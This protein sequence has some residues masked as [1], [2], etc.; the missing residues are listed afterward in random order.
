[1]CRSGLLL[2]IL[3]GC[4]IAEPDDLGPDAATGA[5]ETTPSGDPT[6]AKITLSH[7][8]STA[9][10]KSASVAC[11]NRDGST[12]E[13][14]WY[15][16]FRLADSNIGS[17][18]VVSAVM[19]GVQEAWGSP[20]IRIQLSTYAGDISPWPEVLDPRLLTPLTAMPYTIPDTFSTAPR[21]VTVPIRANVPALS[22]L[23]FEIFAPTYEGNYRYFYLGG[24]S[25]G[26]TA[27]T[28]LRAP[29]DL[30]N[31]PEPRSTTALGFPTS[32]LVLAVHGTYSPR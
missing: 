31:T 27:P 17:G 2:A 29:S 23:V 1:M 16:V 3:G 24:N 18:L 19:F 21:L 28:Y 8:M 6:Y 12:A 26:E 4:A 32:N 11:G 22:Q 10:E 5:S 13:N 7:S 14:S 15:R 30:C 9:I 20:E 25:A